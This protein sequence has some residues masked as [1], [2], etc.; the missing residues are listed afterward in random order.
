[1][2]V[3]WYLILIFIVPEEECTS[4]RPGIVKNLRDLFE[5]PKNF[6]WKED[7]KVI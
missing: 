1:M 7:T 5:D 2:S 6:E 4:P 3:T